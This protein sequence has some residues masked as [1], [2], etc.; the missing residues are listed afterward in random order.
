[1]VIYTK[2]NCGAH[3]FNNW[4][5]VINLIVNLVRGNLMRDQGLWMGFLIYLYDTSSDIVYKQTKGW[6]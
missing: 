5:Y 6:G 3:G 4:W 1:M 2:N